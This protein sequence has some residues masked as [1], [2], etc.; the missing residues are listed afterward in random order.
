MQSSVYEYTGPRLRKVRFKVYRDALGV[1]LPQNL[2][3]YGRQIKRCASVVEDTMKSSLLNV[4]RTADEAFDVQSRSH[5]GDE[6]R[7]RGRRSGPDAQDL[8][9]QR[10]P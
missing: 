9:N 8:L 1:E 6:G 3:I 7:G 4:H 5:S 2:G 10:R